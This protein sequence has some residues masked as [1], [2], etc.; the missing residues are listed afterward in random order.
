MLLVAAALF[1][2]FAYGFAAGSYRLPPFYQ[3]AWIK[4][5]II[6]RV[7]PPAPEYEPPT[8]QSATILE[9]ALQRLLVKRVALPNANEEFVGGGGLAAAGDLLYVVTSDGAVSAMDMR[10]IKRLRSDLD[11]VPLNTADLMRTKVRYQITLYWFRVSGAFAE[12]VDDST[13]RLFV[14]HNR[15]DPARA[16]FTYN[17]SRATV[18]RR[19]DALAARG[20]WQ[21]IYTT[22]PCMTLQGSEGFGRHPFSGHIS[23]GK[24]IAYDRQRLLI[25]VGDF[26]YDGYLRDAWSMDRSNPYGKYVLL[27]KESGKA[28]IFAIG[29]RNDMGLFRDSS[30]TIWATESGPQGGDELNV[31]ERGANYGWPTSTYGIGYESSPWPPATAQGRHDAHKHPI[32]A[33]LPSVVPTNLIR[34]EG[35]PGQFENWRGDLLIATL[36]DQALHRL[37]FDGVGRVVYDERIPFGDRIRDLM[38]LPDGTLV[39]L[40]D[41]TGQLVIIE[42]GG[43]EF[44]PVTEATR[45]RLAALDRYDVLNDAATL[46]AGARSDGEGLFAQKCASC[47][48]LDGRT[49]VGPALDGVLTRRIGSRP[50]YTYSTTLGTDGRDWTPELLVRFLLHP[51]TD[52][53][54]TRMQKVTLTHA[55]TDSIIAYLGRLSR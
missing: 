47:H 21:T 22:A 8:A 20:P 27:D 2:V 36:R 46:A 6:E 50:G 14:S 24:M 15:F 55:Q 1:A 25:T 26:N 51:E 9:T 19:G 32:Y 40:T 31:V 12:V 41:A 3:V 37:R 28:E 29:A 5:T 34:F 7:A 17:I 23:G 35:H 53:V 13:Q 43:A 49:L 52:F 38:R 33:W 54:N 30:G 45:A 16:C 39:L 4:N 11:T 10:A 18:V 48:A 42:D 44:E